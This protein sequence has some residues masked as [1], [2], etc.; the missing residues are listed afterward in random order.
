MNYSCFWQKDI[1]INSEPRK[2]REF[3][4]QKKAVWWHAND[5]QGAFKYLLRLVQRSVFAGSQQ[6]YFTTY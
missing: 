3:C 1:G 5:I 4:R 6:L 2:A